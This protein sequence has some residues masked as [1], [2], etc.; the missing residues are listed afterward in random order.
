MCSTSVR[1]PQCIQADE[2]FVVLTIADVTKNDDSSPVVIGL[3]V[4]I[5]LIMRVARPSNNARKVPP[6]CRFAIRDLPALL[7]PC[8]AGHVVFVK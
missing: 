7:V 8:D 1:L 3:A 5:V 2:V 6:I 4:E